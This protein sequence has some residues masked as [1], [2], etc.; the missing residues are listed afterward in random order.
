MSS[1][2]RTYVNGQ[3]GTYEIVFST[4]N[5]EHYRFVQDACRQAIGHNKPS[6][7]PIK[8]GRWLLTISHNEA[9]RYW[10]D[11]KCSECGNSIGT[12]AMAYFPVIAQ[13]FVE[14]IIGKMAETAKKPKYCVECGAK[15]EG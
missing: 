8:H 2:F 3:K 1:E 7:A 13:E 4:D 12:V 14:P 15:M 9:Y 6:V 10:V 11:A 5:K